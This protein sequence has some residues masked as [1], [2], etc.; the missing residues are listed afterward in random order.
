ML[1]WM[2]IDE[3]YEGYYL[4]AIFNS[5]F[6]RSRVERYQAVGQWGVRHF[7]KMMFNLPIPKFDP[8]L[9]P[10]R[11]LAAAAE[12]AEKI[13]AT[14]PLQE[15]EHFTRARKRIR[16]ALREDGVADAIDRLVEHLLSANAKQIAA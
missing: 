13:A 10:H 15:G 2:R 7:D 14:V 16:N 9:K 5:E 1:Y 3:D 11:E 6:L 8:K 12:H 4:I